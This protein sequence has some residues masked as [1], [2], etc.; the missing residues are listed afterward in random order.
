MVF[1][2]LKNKYNFKHII[3]NFILINI[4]LNTHNITLDNGLLL[5]ADYA[6]VMSFSLLPLLSPPRT[7]SVSLVALASLRRWKS[8]WAQ[9][10]R[11]NFDELNAVT[12]PIACAHSPDSRCHA[13]KDGLRISL[14]F[15]FWWWDGGGGFFCE[16]VSS[17]RCVLV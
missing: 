13:V 9:Q 10:I 4:Y 6:V 7:H 16:V 12:S 8:V 14:G 2:L 5:G 11:I 1:L 17:S 15:F 3:Y